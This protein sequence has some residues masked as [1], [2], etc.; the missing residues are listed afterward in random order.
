MLAFDLE[1]TGLDPE[2]HIITCACAYDPD[3][4]IAEAFTFAREGEAEEFMA[5]LDRADRLCAFNGAAFDLPFIARTL[6]GATP[7]RVRAW[8]LKLHD[9]FVACKWGLGVTF[10]LQKLLELNSLGGKTGS[11]KDAILLHEQGRTEELVAY[12]MNDTRVTHAVSSLDAILLPKTRGI[13]LDCA[14]VFQPLRF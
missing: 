5:L 13:T 9:V 11:G 8:R 14:G 6:P 1:T 3:A 10:S 2:V 4:G 7:G 12:C